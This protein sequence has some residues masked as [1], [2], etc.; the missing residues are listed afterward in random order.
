MSSR[1]LDISKGMILGIF[2]DKQGKSKIYNDTF[3]HKII[4]LDLYKQHDYVDLPFY[5]RMDDKNI[6]GKGRGLIQGNIGIKLRHF[7]NHVG[8]LVKECFKYVYTGDLGGMKGKVL[9]KWIL[10]ESSYKWLDEG[11]KGEDKIYYDLSQR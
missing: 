6:K 11:N 1:E 3:D 5:L 7:L 10:I 2:Y 8:H 9:D 4:T